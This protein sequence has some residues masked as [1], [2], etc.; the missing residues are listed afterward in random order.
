VDDGEEGIEAVKEG[1]EEV[2]SLVG[3]DVGREGASEWGEWW[4]KTVKGEL[5]VVAAVL[6]GLSSFK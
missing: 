4:L 1:V 3:S 5:E 6:A 2:K